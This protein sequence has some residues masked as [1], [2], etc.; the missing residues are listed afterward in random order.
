MDEG[1]VMD[2]AYLDFSKAFY[3]VSHFFLLDKL[4]LIGLDPIVSSWIKSF[5]IG[6][7]M[8]AS[9]SDTTSLSIPVTSGFLQGF[10]SGPLLFLWLAAGFRLQTTLSCVFVT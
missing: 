9:I 3:V 5:L 6:R 7:T 8:S 10:V 2:M 1:K 4:Q